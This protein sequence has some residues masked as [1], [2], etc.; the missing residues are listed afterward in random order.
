LLGLVTS[1]H[2]KNLRWLSTDSLGL[3]MRGYEHVVEATR[4]TLPNLE[5]FNSTYNQIDDPMEREPAT[6][7]YSGLPVYETVG[8]LPLAGQVLEG[9]YGYQK[10]LHWCSRFGP[11]M[12]KW[13]F[14]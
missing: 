13:P 10:I 7:G 5:I 8:I 11:S 1:R 2:L 14:D 12:E 6:D 9:N 4:T 3:T